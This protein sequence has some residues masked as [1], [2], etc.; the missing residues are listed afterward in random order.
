MFALAP[1][2]TSE[3]VSELIRLIEGE[4]GGNCSIKDVSAND[5]YALW[6][7]SWQSNEGTDVVIRVME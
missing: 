6:E 5:K 1:N 2:P 7:V 4:C 3:G